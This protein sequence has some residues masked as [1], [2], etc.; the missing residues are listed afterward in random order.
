MP[1]AG[2]S[3]ADDGLDGVAALAVGRPAEAFRAAGAAREHIDFVGDHEG[4]IEADAELADQGRVFAT[5]CLAGFLARFELFHERLGARARDGAERLDHLVVAHADAVVLDGEAGRLGV[6][7]D[8][9]A[10]LGVIAEQFGLGDGFVAE[11]LAGVGGVGD[12]LAEEHILVGIDRVHHEVQ[13][14][15]NVGFERPAFRL[16]FGGSGHGGQVSGNDSTR[17]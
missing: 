10:G 15:G 2:A 16:G 3:S 1:R 12:Q 11:P 9:D 6:D 17:A 4:R 14:A 13:Q 8:G 7:P 5:G